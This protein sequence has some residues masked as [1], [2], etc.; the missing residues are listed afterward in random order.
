[1]GVPLSPLSASFA[2]SMRA[3]GSAAAGWYRTA[4]RWALAFS[5]GLS[6]LIHGA[7]VA[8]VHWESAGR[9]DPGDSQ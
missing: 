2:F 6:A 8:A 5:C 3:S 1:M 7:Y 4:Y 9:C